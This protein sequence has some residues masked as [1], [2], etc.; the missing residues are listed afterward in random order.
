MN[1]VTVRAATQTEVPA[2]ARE[3]Q[4]ELVLAT[5]TA[6]ACRSVLENPTGLELVDYLADDLAPVTP[7]ARKAL[8]VY[9][10]I[11][12]TFGHQHRCR[13]AD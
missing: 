3:R 5:T 6:H 10:A 11:L 12:V 7:A 1:D 9:R 4:Q 13:E 2:L 8:I